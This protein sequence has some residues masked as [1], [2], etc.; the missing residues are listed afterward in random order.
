MGIKE[1]GGGEMRFLHTLDPDDFRDLDRALEDAA[2]A[3][4]LE[5]EDRVM[6]RY[7]E[8]REKEKTN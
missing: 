5:K 4:V 1:D 8:K 3:A 6:E 7:Y 2:R